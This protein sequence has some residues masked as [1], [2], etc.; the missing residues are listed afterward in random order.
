MYYF[1]YTP[2]KVNLLIL[3]WRCS[4]TETIAIAIVI[5]KNF[6]IL[7]YF[8]DSQILLMNM[9]FVYFR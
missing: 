4:Y 1:K 7:N 3:K 6:L 5:A 2:K 8:Y 9:L